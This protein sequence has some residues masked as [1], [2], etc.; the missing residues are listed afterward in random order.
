MENRETL[1]ASDNAG[2][3]GTV[4]AFHLF[5]PFHGKWFMVFFR[6]F[7]VLDQLFSP[8]GTGPTRGPQQTFKGATG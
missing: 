6:N 5:P 8:R 7:S 2:H 3:V 4:V 1:P